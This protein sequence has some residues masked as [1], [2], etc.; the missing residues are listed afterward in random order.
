MFVLN[1]SGRCSA[2]TP[3]LRQAV[4]FAVDR[5]ALLRE[6][7][8]ARRHADRP[9]PAAGHA[10]LPERAHLPAQGPRPEE[11][12]SAREG[13]HPQRQGGAVH[14]REPGR[15]RPGTDRQG[16]PE[17]R[18]GS[19]SRSRRFRARRPVR[20]SWRRPASRSTSA[21]SA[22]SASRDESPSSTPVRR[23][24]DRRA[25]TSAT[26][27]TSTRRSTT[28]CSTRRR[29]FRSG[30]ALPGVRRARR[31]HR[32]ERGAGDR[33]IAYDQRAHARR[34]RTGCVVMNP[35]ST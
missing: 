35:T 16:Q 13:A 29:G 14:V 23:P 22:G 9:V 5:R 32:E 21:G 3:Q 30:R 1:T 26:S 34:A 17:A 7:W 33:R 10:G 2:T 18:S 8:A 15:R 11:G 28:G 20:R 27:R 6:R 4:N 12:A 24:H 31:R 25:R 19:R